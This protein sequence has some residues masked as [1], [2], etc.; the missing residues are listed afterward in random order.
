MRSWRLFSEAAVVLRDRV[1]LG[2]S[3]VAVM[4]PP[5]PCLD[6][7]IDHHV[8]VNFCQRQRRET[9]WRL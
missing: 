7:F 5:N 3:T 1:A 8:G 6:I 4:L 2:F 9:R